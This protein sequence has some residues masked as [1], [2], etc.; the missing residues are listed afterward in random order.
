MKRQRYGSV[1]LCLGLFVLPLAVQAEQI[2]R[3][4]S[5]APDTLVEIHNLNGRVV[6]HA[7]NQPEVKVVALRRSRAVEVHLEQLANRIHIHTHLLQA[8]APASDRAVDLE[9]WARPDVHLMV[10]SEAGELL[11]EDFVQDV[12]IKTFAADI[13]LRNL[14]GMAAVETL[15]GTIRLERCSGRLEVTSISG[16]LYLDDITS[17]LVVAKT[18][19]G[20]IYYRGG[21]Q[22][23]GDYSFVNHEGA[24]ELRVPATASFELRANSVKGEVINE[25]PITTRRHGR[26]PLPTT[27]RSLLGTVH[28]GDAMVRAT[29]FSG[30]IRLRKQ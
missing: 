8:S 30:T 16:S 29:S 27:E 5:A 3:T 28:T 13:I 20:D 18:T 25:L 9:I 12:S 10:Q 11:V 1:V 17:R 21:F 23:G 7:W 19:S 26:L 4:F 15:N 2:E 14:A 22:P 6:V 24:I